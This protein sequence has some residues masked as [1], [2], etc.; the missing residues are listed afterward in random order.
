MVG[1]K[2]RLIIALDFDTAADAVAMCR[3]VGDQ[4]CFYKVGLQ[5]FLSAGRDVVD[6]VKNLGNHIFLDLKLHDIPNTVA[7]ACREIV[8]VG[9]S[10]TTLHT[11]GGAD[12][13]RE[14]ATATKRAAEE[15]GV[16]Q[17]IL[18]GVTM[19]TSLN[20][21]RAGEIGVAGSISEQVT[22][23][24]ILAKT[25]GLDGVVASPHEVEGLRCELG[26]DFI[27]VT[28]G[29]RSA[30]D[31]VHDQKRVMSALDAIAAGSSYLVVGR[32]VTEADNP[33]KAAASIIAQIRQASA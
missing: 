8:R 16:E 6:Q 11:M 12:M 4:A 25:S 10:M 33:A 31:A 15:F 24:A 26:D 23:L 29:I 30:A 9:V 2:E 17:P 28:P 14:A 7:G 19:L 1:P 27:I 3:A 18:L 21:Q 20:E 22:R 13:M 32:P 5:L